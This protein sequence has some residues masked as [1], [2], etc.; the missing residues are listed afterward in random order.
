MK[1]IKEFLSNKNIII[2]MCAIVILGLSIALVISLNVDNNQNN[3]SNNNTETNI[4]NGDENLLEE[5]EDEKNDEENKDNFDSN[6]NKPSNSSNSHKKENTTQKPTTEDNSKKEDIQTNNNSSNTNKTYIC[7]SGYTLS[8][9]KAKCYK[10]TELVKKYK[11]ENDYTLNSDNTCTGI[12]RK[13]ADEGIICETGDSGGWETGSSKA[14]CYKKQI[15]YLDGEEECIANGYY[16]VRNGSFRGCYTE[17]YESNNYEY[18]CGNNGK[19][20]NDPNDKKYC[21]RYE[22]ISATE[23]YGCD[24][25]YTLNSSKDSCIKTIASTIKE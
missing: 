18:Y 11:C 9:D 7:P 13:L 20:S 19:W 1:K 8:N 23:Y 14:Y 5:I 24:D 16:Y 25:G 12:V 4:E 15:Y 10:V 21:Y 17:K 3:T 22:T 6:N 2:I